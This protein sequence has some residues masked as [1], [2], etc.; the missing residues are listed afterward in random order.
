MSL[1]TVETPEITLARE[2]YLAAQTQGNRFDVVIAVEALL[3]AKLASFQTL[4]LVEATGV[5]PIEIERQKAIARR[6][7]ADVIQAQEP[8]PTRAI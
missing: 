6:R 3:D 1:T 8:S 2:T 4:G 7:A 5:H